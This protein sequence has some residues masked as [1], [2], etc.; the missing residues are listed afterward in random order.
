LDDTARKYAGFDAEA[1]WLITDIAGRPAGFRIKTLSEG[2]D[3]VDWAALEIEIA[4]YAAGGKAA[5]SI[6]ECTED[7]DRFLW[8]TGETTM[9]SLTAASQIELSP[10][11]R[12][13]VGKASGRQYWPGPGA[14]PDIWLDLVCAKFLD[15]Y[16][17]R[18]VIDVIFAD[19]RIIPALI[20]SVDASQDNRNKWGASYAVR[21]DFLTG[22]S[23]W[24]QTYYDFKKQPVGR[25]ER[26]EETLIWHRTDRQTLVEKFGNLERY[27]GKGSILN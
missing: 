9:R 20:S 24:R 7:A 4:Q 14:A 19:G 26:G 15:S 21:V 27:L 6:F 2:A 5:F 25:V 22:D 17:D 18:A 10:D 3:T 16:M 23:N 13:R 8:Q 12:M 1:A 11:G